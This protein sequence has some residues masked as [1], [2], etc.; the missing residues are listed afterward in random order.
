MRP[1]VDHL[2][3]WRASRGPAGRTQRRRA[4]LD[5]QD[6]GHPRRADRPRLLS[7]GSAHERR[8]DRQRTA[9]GDHV[10]D[11]PAVRVTAAPWPDRRHAWPADPARHD[12][13]D[14]GSVPFRYREKPVQHHRHRRGQLRQSRRHTDTDDVA[15]YSRVFN[16]PTEDQGGVTVGDQIARR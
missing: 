10:A 11:A 9:D 7:R 1:R 14:A 2:R 15:P 16:E 8:A 5:G 4:D 3:Q 12:R 6:L 13:R